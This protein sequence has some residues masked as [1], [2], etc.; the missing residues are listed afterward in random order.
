MADLAPAPD[1]S[2]APALLS[3]SDLA[4]ARG[5]RPVFA[6]LS[7]TLDP[8][9]ALRLAG[10]NGGGKSTVLRVVAGLLSPAKGQVSWAGTPV[11]DDMGAHARRIAYLG[12]ADA[13]KS[14]LTAREN[15][16]TA[17]AVAGR[18]AS[19]A[20][21]RA[22]ALLDLQR[23][24]DL[25]AGWLSAG[26]R[27]RAALAR[28][29]ASGCPLWLLDEPTVGLDTA[30]VAALERAIAE[31][32]SAGGMVIAATH[33]A[34]DLGPGDVSLDPGAFPWTPAHAPFDEAL[35]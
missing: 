12:H 19:E 18:K 28:I 22:F 6:A 31:H 4:V 15:A 23:L 20:L 5:G 8:G 34:L 3:A 13:L 9:G 11:T 30:S 1:L 27:R 21:D 14:A 10:P 7:F 17:L 33:I 26:Q 2:P 25:P 29:V 35:V 24:A 16:E 32:R